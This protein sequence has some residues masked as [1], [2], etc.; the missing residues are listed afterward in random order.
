MNEDAFVETLISVDILGNEAVA[1]MQL[2]F[3]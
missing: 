2:T 3:D 1:F